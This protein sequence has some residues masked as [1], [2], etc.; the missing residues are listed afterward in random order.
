MDTHERLRELLNER[1]WTAYRL[2]KYC[3]LSEST[4]SNLFRRNTLPSI[5]T[6]EAVCNGFGITLAQFFAEKEMIEVTPELQELIEC[7]KPLT[8]EQKTAML[9]MI[10]AMSRNGK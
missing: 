6:L 7:W 9:Q 8:P 5:D 4:V 3:G 2:A 10:R 1:G